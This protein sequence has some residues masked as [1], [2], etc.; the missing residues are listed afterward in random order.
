MVRHTLKIL[1][2]LQDFVFGHFGTLCI[3]GTVWKVS[4][5]EFFSGPFFPVFGPEKPPYLGIFHAV[6]VK[7]YELDLVFMF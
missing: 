3:K 4:K 5:Y 1:Q 2:H 6:K 7:E